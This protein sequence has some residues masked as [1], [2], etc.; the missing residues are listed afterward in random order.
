MQ[1]RSWLLRTLAAVAVLAAPAATRAADLD[2]STTLTFTVPIE[3]PTT[4]LQPGAYVFETDK[5]EGGRRAVRIYSSD[6]SKL[7]V[8]TQAVS[9]TRDG[10]ADVAYYRPTILDSAPTALRAWFP[11]GSNAGYQLV[12]PAKEAATI[13][14]RT[15]E[16]V[17]TADN[18]TTPLE[19]VDAYGKRTPWS[20][21]SGSAS[22][23]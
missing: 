9:A 21:Q 10:A 7:I 3:V 1:M 2:N 20:A 22:G 5:E 17:I 16:R 14:N 12:Y 8:T 15:S 4:T 11:T 19:V 23:E 13:A 6:K 18:T